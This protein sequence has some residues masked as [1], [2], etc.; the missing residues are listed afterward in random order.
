ML[1]VRARA[2]RFRGSLLV[3]G[4]AWA[5]ATLAGPDEA[6]A[7]SDEVPPAS[8]PSS[9][10]TPSADFGAAPGVT[11]APEP[12]TA[13]PDSQ[14]SITAPTRPATTPDPCPEA[15]APNSHGATAHWSAP[16][17]LEVPPEEPDGGDPKFL[18][19]A[20]F[21]TYGA[22]W[23][24]D[25]NGQKFLAAPD[26]SAIELVLIPELRSST[27]L[28]FEGCFG[29]MRPGYWGFWLCLAYARSYRWGTFAGVEVGEVV[30]DEG[31]VPARVM[32]PADNPFRPYLDMSVG[33]GRFTAEKA[34]G[35]VDG[36]GNVLGR[37]GDAVFGIGASFGI[38][39]GAVFFLAENIA[40]DVRFGYRAYAF[41]S[42]NGREVEDGL[43]AGAYDVRLGPALY[44]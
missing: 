21:L 7:T 11:A 18:S 36:N 28:S 29:G 16:P 40:F 17:S 20:G 6:S 35:F 31:F 24:T 26:D 13:E 43:G 4:V 33:F 32:F 38:G 14:A 5:R 42:V 23:G 25:F 12:A 34:A 41:D 30:S 9:D 22:L 44:F 10:T 27:G 3:M 37:P 15:N 19:F 1:G 39:V 8:D 2:L